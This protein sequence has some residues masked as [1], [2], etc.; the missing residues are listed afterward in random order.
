MSAYRNNNNNRNNNYQNN[1]GGNNYQNNR[2]NRGGNNRGNAPTY[3]ITTSCDKEAVDNKCYYKK[4]AI[5]PSLDREVIDSLNMT[6]EN[7]IFSTIN[8]YCNKIN[9]IIKENLALFGVFP[10][11]CTIVDGSSGVG[12][13][14]ISFSEI[15]QTVYA[16][17][18]DKDTFDILNYVIE[19][20]ERQNIE[21]INDNIVDVIDTFDK[22]DVLFLDPIWGDKCNL[23]TKIKLKINK[24]PVEEF[25]SDVLSKRPELLIAIK[26]PLN[27]N[28]EHLMN[29][30][31][32]YKCK[33]YN[34]K[35]ML[36]MIINT[37]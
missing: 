30:L 9:K 31:P 8:S 5:F 35:K 20:H 36:V 13:N 2:G 25:C 11:T 10:D 23:P 7:I 18:K 21:T 15:F 4:Y 32:E 1:R 28:I 17:E 37:A 14:T 33:E 24:I 12:G 29:S 6:N 3:Y 27:Y 19:L 34:L 22:I 16:V 26:L